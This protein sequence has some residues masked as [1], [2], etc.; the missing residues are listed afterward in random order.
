HVPSE[1]IYNPVYDKMTLRCEN[2]NGEKYLLY[3]GKINIKRHPKLLI[4]V[5]IMLEEI[6]PELKLYFLGTGQNEILNNCS[7]NKFPQNIKVFDWSDKPEEY[8]KNALA[9]VDVDINKKEDVFISG[10]L[11]SYLNSN[12][13][14]LSIT[15]ED[16]PSSKL[17]KNLK[18]GVFI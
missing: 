9:L 1:V 13:P 18:H 12:I 10:K 17:L 3:A 6:L 11:M 5:M 2:Y 15:T 16:S 7:E 4:Q 8:M 14:I